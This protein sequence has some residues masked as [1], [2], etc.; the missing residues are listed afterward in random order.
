MALG[1]T[2]IVTALV[3]AGT[4]AIVPARADDDAHALVARVLGAVPKVALQAHATLTSDRGWVRE[5][6]L[7]RAFVG[8]ADASYLEVTAPLD[9]K[10]TRFLLFDRAAGRD[11]QF[12]YVP[13][14]KRAMQISDETR[15]QPFLGSD[16]YVSDMVRPELDAFDYT[17]V[18]E[19][20]IGD[21]A[22][23]LVQAVPKKP[24]GAL[25]GKTVSAIDPADL[26]VLRVQFY[27]PQGALQKVWTLD[28]VE[29]VEGIWTPLVQR[30]TNLQEKH[31]SKIALTDV[32]YNA[33]IP[34]D[35]FNRSYLTR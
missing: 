11:E 1:I 30:M 26:L 2:R 29:K 10:D 19:E 35:T 7:S 27:D 31:E 25:Y 28:K 17:F 8:D 24:E 6:A 5:L 14:V 18:G 20:K 34:P 13:Q 23:R 33:E 9:L 21:R 12:M 32:K 4:A 15:K 16:F 3:L 22:T